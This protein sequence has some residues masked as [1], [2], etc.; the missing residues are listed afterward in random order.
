MQTMKKML[1]VAGIVVAAAACKNY[2]PR[3]EYDQV[4]QEYQAL[5]D[6]AGALQDSYDEQVAAMDGILS[7]LS[8]IS[9]KTYSLRV[10]LENGSAG[11]SQAEQIEE[12]ISDIKGKL[13]ELDKVTQANT[14]NKRL[15]ASL[16]KVVAEKESEIASLKE[17]I[18]RKDRTIAEQKATITSQTGRIQEQDETIS[19][20]QGK[21]RQAVLD[22]ARLLYQAGADFEELGD[23]TPDV[24]R[25]RDKQKVQDF[26]LEM[27]E[28]ALL[29]YTKARESGY[30]EAELRIIGVQQKI[31]AVR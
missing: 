24:R 27:Y 26:T 8:E 30:V 1:A 4:V 21:L 12:S 10:G 22:Q 2:V 15:V 14:A 20:Q 3:A 31:E 19:I 23:S 29:Y 25:R 16:R 5:K 11:L 13:A 28:K 9:G 6:D 18:L 17:D 7:E